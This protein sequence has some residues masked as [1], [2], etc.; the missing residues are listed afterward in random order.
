MW[1]MYGFYGG[2]TAQ[3]G[4]TQG[5]HKDHEMNRDRKMVE[6]EK[7]SFEFG[8]ADLLNTAKRGLAQG[9]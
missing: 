7:D 3:T 1:I 6:R 8:R 4:V 9:P 2:E 5:L